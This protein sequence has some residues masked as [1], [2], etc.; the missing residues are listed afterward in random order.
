MV[1]THYSC[2]QVPLESILLAQLSTVAVGGHS[3][4]KVQYLHSEVAAGGLFEGMEFYII[5]ALG[6]PFESKVLT[7]TVVGGLFAS[8]VLTYYS[9][10]KAPSI[11]FKSRIGLLTDFSGCWGPFESRLPSNCSCCW[12]PL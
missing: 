1:L 9:F 11:K 10:F 3:E 2:C 8:R 12:G 5:I 6:G 7:F 4:S